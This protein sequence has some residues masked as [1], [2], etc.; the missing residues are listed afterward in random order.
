MDASNAAARWDPRAPDVLQDQVRAYDAMRGRCPVAHS[1]YLQWS[2]F[3][4]ADVLR[5]LH[6]PATFGNEVSRHLSI[7]N[8]MDPPRHTEW[9]ALVDRYFEPP[10]VARF[11]PVARRIA[12]ECVAALP[13]EELEWMGDFAHGCAVRLLCAFMDWPDTLGAPLRDWALRNR[14]ATLA[15]DRAVL[16]A[17]AFEFDGH[18]R[19]R[20]A[21]EHDRVEDIGDV[22]RLN[23]DAGRTVD[24]DAAGQALIG[25]E[26]IGFGFP[27]DGAGAGIHDIVFEN[28]IVAVADRHQ[29]GMDDSAI[30][31]SLRLA[32]A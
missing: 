30:G 7:P 15:G 3:R 13:G 8:G 29:A 17:M 16:A 1:E 32:E 11:E 5:V 27:F 12:R 2:L 21:A 10:R 28:D 18:I 9:R 31:P 22:V 25:G 23:G 20:I 6:N 14:A 4:H 19:A 26:G 24:A